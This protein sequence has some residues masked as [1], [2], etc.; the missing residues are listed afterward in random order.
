MK[1]IIISI[2]FVILLFNS[3]DIDELSA[4]ECLV[5]GDITGDDRLDARDF[6]VLKDWLLTGDNNACDICNAD[7]NNDGEVNVLD[8]SGMKRIFFSK[9]EP[10]LFDT[11]DTLPYNKSSALYCVDDKSVLYSYNIN[12]KIAPASLTKLLTASIALHYMDSNKVITVG[13][14]QNL[15]KSGSSLCLVRP[16][17]RM[18]LYDLLTGMLMNSGNDAAYAVAVSTARSVF[19]EK[20]LN[21]S[22]AVEHFSFLMNDYAESIG[23][24]SSHFKTPEGWDD[25]AQYTTVRDLL[26]LSRHALSIPEIRS[27]IGTAQKRVVIESGEIFNWS[28]TNRLLDPNSTFYNKNAIGMKTGTTNN[29]GCCLIGAFEVKDKTY[30]SIVVGCNSNNDR[31]SIVSEL[32]SKV[33]FDR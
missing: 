31:Y 26:L 24:K 6:L 10:L 15:V 21:D 25:D 17:H 22:Q 30:I 8:L 23:M 5:E 18:K 33:N 29:A 14:E 19:P 1:K 3:L 16:G 2:L 9:K 13:S 32:I 28:N 12:D 11:P 20:N 4:Y 7:L 27:I